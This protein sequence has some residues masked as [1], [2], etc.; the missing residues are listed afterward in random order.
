MGNKYDEIP[1]D[2]EPK[3]EKV[4]MEVRWPSV[5]MAGGHPLGAIYYG[6]NQVDLGRVKKNGPK[7]LMQEPNED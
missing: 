7:G 5:E 1:C 4:V 2:T 3:D 6:N